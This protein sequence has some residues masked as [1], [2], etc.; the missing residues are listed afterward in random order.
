V[1]GRGGDEGFKVRGGGSWAEG[2]VCLTRREGLERHMG[3]WGCK[4]C[5]MIMR[6]WCLKGKGEGGSWRG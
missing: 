4:D 6:V 2:D 3:R 1:C 5:D